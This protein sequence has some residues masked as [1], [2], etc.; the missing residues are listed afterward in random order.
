M[1]H[2]NRVAKSDAK[3]GFARPIDFDLAGPIRSG[4][5][6]NISF[7]RLD[8]RLKISLHYDSR[9]ILAALESN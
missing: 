1:I 3:P 7:A 2:L 4:T 9:V 6:L 5:P 8:R